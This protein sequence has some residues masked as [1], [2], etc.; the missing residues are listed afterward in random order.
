M[1]G[2]KVRRNQIIWA[3]RVSSQVGHIIYIAPNR[4]SAN[5]RWENG[6]IFQYRLLDNERT[7][8]I[9]AE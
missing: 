8:L 1:L 3:G 2:M 7:S 5:V 6:I 4:S 9:T